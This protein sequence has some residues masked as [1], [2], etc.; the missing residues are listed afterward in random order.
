MCLFL[1]QEDKMRIGKKSL[2]VIRSGGQSGVDRAAL[3]IAKDF[4]LQVRGWCPKGGWAEDLPTPPGVLRLYPELKE[5]PDTNTSDRTD[6]NVR[7]SN[8][9]LVIWPCN[10]ISSP[11]TMLSVQMTAQRG[12]PRFLVKKPEDMEAALKWL[13]GLPQPLDLNIVGPR[14][15]EWDRAYE[16]SYLFLRKLLT[17]YLGRG[18]KH[19]E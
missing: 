1:R 4:D 12:K 7:D 14:E 17:S 19:L 15:S 9:T 18:P 16:K 13:E 3:D 6:W 8:A 5:T 11:G 10:G 2:F